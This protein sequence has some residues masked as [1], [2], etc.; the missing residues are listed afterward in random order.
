MR[1]VL[2]AALA[3]TVLV[4]STVSAQS[5][6]EIRHDQREVARDVNRGHYREAREDQQELNRDL[7]DYRQRH[8][9]LYNRPAYVWPNGHRYTA[10]T[11]G[12]TLDNV[13]WGPR[14][15]ISNY[16][17]YRLPYPGAHR[18]WVRYGNDAV[19]MNRR[20]GRIITVY[21]DFFF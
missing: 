10:L 2:I 3:A 7:R 16:S 17:T 20:T 15:R 4:P 1:N 11:V 5:A 8:R 21:N 14:Y 12:S 18:Q 9:H 13:F 19:L 6:H